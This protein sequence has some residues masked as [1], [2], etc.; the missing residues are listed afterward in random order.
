M[1]ELERIRSLSEKEQHKVIVDNSEEFFDY[2]E[3]VMCENPHGLEDVHYSELLAHIGFEL[4][5]LTKAVEK[6]G[7][8]NG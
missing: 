8:R 6:L 2:V 4:Y 1:T 7:E 3:F 5:K